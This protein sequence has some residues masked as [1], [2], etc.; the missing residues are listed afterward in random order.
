MWTKHIIQI[1]G[2]FQLPRFLI[3]IYFANRR[4]QL[5][6]GCA[7]LRYLHSR[8]TA[9]KV[10][11]II[12]VQLLS[13]L[14]PVTP[15]AL[16]AARFLVGHE[17]GGAGSASPAPGNSAENLFCKAVF[18]F[19]CIV[20]FSS[21]WSRMLSKA[22]H[23]NRAYSRSIFSS[24]TWY[25]YHEFSCS[26]PNAEIIPFPSHFKVFLIREIQLCSA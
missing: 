17:R 5:P 3:L 7:L 24:E 4:A 20:F 8:K 18:I 23:K 11:M 21:T 16:S 15:T 22:G 12:W 6:G 10:R 1:W 9:M 14:P 2:Y 13:N 19:Q 26:C 25:R